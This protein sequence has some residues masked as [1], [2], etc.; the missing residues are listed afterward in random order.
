MSN[1]TVGFQQESQAKSLNKPIEKRCSF[2]Y[3]FCIDCWELSD[4]F[5]ERFGGLEGFLQRLLGLF[6]LGLDVLGGSQ[7]AASVWKGI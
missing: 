4:W 7:G 1:K 3:G 6:V 5:G 2:R